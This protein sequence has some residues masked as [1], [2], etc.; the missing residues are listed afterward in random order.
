MDMIEE[1]Y[2]SALDRASLEAFEGVFDATEIAEKVDERGIKEKALEM[3][4]AAQ[5]QN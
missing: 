3:V 5:K 1:T 4:I 2:E